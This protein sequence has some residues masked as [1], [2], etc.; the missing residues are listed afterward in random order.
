MQVLDLNLAEEDTINIYEYVQLWRPSLMTS[1]ES[2]ANGLSV[3]ATTSGDNMLVV[4]DMG[5]LAPGSGFIAQYFLG[6]IHFLYPY[7]G[8]GN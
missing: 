1:F 3:S 5:S 7:Y 8:T 2:S 4:M 6:K